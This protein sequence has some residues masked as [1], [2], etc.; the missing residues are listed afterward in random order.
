M[1]I[2]VKMLG[3]IQRLS[4]RNHNTV[5]NHSVDRRIAHL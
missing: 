1:E 2:T 4:S 5:I 3:Q